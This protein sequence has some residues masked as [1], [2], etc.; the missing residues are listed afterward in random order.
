MTTI[1]APKPPF[2]KDILHELPASSGKACL[3][4][5]QVS[6]VVPNEGAR[7]PAYLLHLDVE[8]PLLDEHQQQYGKSCYKSS[9]QLCS[10]YQ[11]EDLEGKQ[12]LCVINFP[13]KQIGPR[14]SD[15]LVTGVQDTSL[16][17][18]EKRKTMTTLEP[19]SEV[20]NGGSFI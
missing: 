12:L 14:K 7:V 9:A 6:Q 10:R 4:I 17:G 3:A 8:R 13:R 16:D 5:A 15:C 19:T 18:E 1:K 2:A 11:K 20:A